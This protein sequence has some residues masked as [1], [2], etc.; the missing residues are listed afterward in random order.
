MMEVDLDSVA[1]PPAAPPLP[2]AK[3]ADSTS[4]GEIGDMMDLNA[5]VQSELEV[6]VFSSQP[7]RLLIT[8]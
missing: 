4:K 8:R 7:F 1:E 2:T 6:R 3:L 5:G